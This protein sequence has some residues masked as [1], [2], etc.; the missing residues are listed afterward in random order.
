MY[1]VLLLVSECFQLFPTSLF[2]TTH[3]ISLGSTMR[4]LLRH[5]VRS[6]DLALA[7]SSAAPL[8]ARA[9]P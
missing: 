9:V 6:H 8:F 2:G 5:L 3:L 7:R 1:I 4:R